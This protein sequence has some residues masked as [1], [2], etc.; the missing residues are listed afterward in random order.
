M[1][2]I[3]P[4][5]IPLA[6]MAVGL[7]FALCATVSEYNYGISQVN[8]HSDKQERA[9]ALTRMKKFLWLKAVGFVVV[10][11]IVCNVVTIVFSWIGAGS[12]N[13]RSGSYPQAATEFGLQAQ[14]EYP[15]TI[16]G[17][18]VGGTAGTISTGFFSTAAITDLRPASA[19][20]L[21][22]S[23]EGSSWIVTIPTDVIEFHLVNDRAPSVAL[24]FK[25]G[26]YGYRAT[27]DNQ[28]TSAF[29]LSNGMLGYVWWYTNPDISLSEAGKRDGLPPIIN[30]GVSH[31]DITLPEALYNQVFNL[32]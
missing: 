5:F 14:T 11:V 3:D 13:G 9:T 26:A 7:I 17:T 10:A 19:V 20:N 24:T 18:A 28:T 31:V 25:S 15:L 1:F 22:F 16:G 8:Q 4:Y 23:Y 21:S 6:I 2:W 30:N 12:D 29:G 32:K 27:W